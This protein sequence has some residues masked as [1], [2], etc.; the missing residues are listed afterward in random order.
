MKKNIAFVVNPISGTSSKR[1]VPELIQKNLDFSHFNQCQIV[2]TAYKGHGRE[3]TQQFVD[4]GFDIVVAVGGDGTVN[5]VAGA[6]IDTDVALGVISTGSGN[7]LARHLKIPTNMKQAIEHLNF[8]EVIKMDYGLVNNEK[9]FFCTC[10]FGF[11]A[12]VSELFSK[13]TKRGFMG[14]MEKMVTGFLNYEPQPYQLVSNEINLEGTAFVITFANASQWGYNAYIAPKA[15]IQDG[16]IDISVIS[17]MPI[18]AIP[19]IAFQLFTKTIQKDKLLV[20]TLRTK[21]IT[22]YRDQPG[23]FHLD[24][25]PYEFGKEIHIEIIPGGLNLMVKKRF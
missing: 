2:I 22:L 12:Y 3:L 16:M 19:S 4:D 14:Y 5:E 11:D 10:G 21:S 13:G 18:I 1:N 9:P 8:S 7:G 15:S 17:N 6:L 20:T 25:D 23:L 24:G